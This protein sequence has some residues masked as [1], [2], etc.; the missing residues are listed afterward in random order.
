ME[1]AAIFWPTPWVA[2]AT[3]TLAAQPTDGLSVRLELRHDRAKTPAYF[4]GDVAGDGV[5]STYVPNRRAQD[6]LT[7]GATAWF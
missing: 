7:L 1:A 6:T 2:S 3:P 4:G 5:T